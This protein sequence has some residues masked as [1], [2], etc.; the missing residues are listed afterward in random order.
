MPQTA[1]YWKQVTQC[2]TQMA[3]IGPTGPQ[4]SIPPLQD[5]LAVKSRLLPPTFQAM[6]HRWKSRCD[7]SREGVPNMVLLLNAVWQGRFSKTPPSRIS[8]AKYPN[9]VE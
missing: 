5:W 7:T 9:R 2:R 4:R 3:L 1:H 8:G 6:K